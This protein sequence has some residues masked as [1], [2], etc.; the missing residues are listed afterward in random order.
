MCNNLIFN[1]I[2]D[3][4]E[5]A[6][7]LESTQ[8]PVQEVAPDDHER[9][10]NRDRGVEVSAVLD[11]AQFLAQGQD[12]DHARVWRDR[13]VRRRAAYRH[14]DRGLN[15]IIGVV[16]ETAIGKDAIRY[17][18]QDP[19]LARDRSLPQGRDR[20][21]NLAVNDREAMIIKCQ[22]CPGKNFSQFYSRIKLL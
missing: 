9:E 18:N 17:Q 12:L 6:R 14:Q 10:V 22:H 21:V 11:R 1:L 4:D 15:R 13:E 5:H 19:S 8:D 3:L 20:E 16:L 2:L 7:D